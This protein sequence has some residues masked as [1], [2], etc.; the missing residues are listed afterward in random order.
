MSDVIKNVKRAIDT[1]PLGSVVYAALDLEHLT[2]HQWIPLLGCSHKRAEIDPRVWKNFPVFKHTVTTR[3]LAVSPGNFGGAASPTYFVVA[4]TA[5]ATGI[6]YSTDGTTWSQTSVSTPA[7]HAARTIIWTGTRFVSFGTSSCATS[8][9]NPNSTWT[10]LTGG[11]SNTNAYNIAAYSPTLGR[12]VFLNPSSS[13]TAL[14]TLDDGSTTLTLRTAPTGTRYAVVWT[15][16]R[17]VTNDSTNI[18]CVSTNGID[19]SAEAKND[20]VFAAAGNRYLQFDMAS[21]GRGTIV[22]VTGAGRFCVSKD[23][24]RSWA[25]LHPTLSGGASI[26]ISRV[27]YDGER[28]FALNTALRNNAYVSYDGSAWAPFAP[29]ALANNANNNF[30]NVLKK[31]ST[32]VGIHAGTTSAFSW[33]EDR[34]TIITQPSQQLAPTSAAPFWNQY[35]KVR[36]E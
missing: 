15:G 3:T 1:L 19:W 5:G 22:A 11:A 28:F 26:A 18:F 32:F 34:T 23:H 21:D 35:M 17:F 9:D 13:T 30:A 4:A 20:V 6:Q 10:S 12:C 24:G 2:N 36:D 25:L 8:G 31:G 33:T 29:H 7:S 14:Y 27:V 16:E